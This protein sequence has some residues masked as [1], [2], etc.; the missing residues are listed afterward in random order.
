[1]IF[2]LGFDASRTG[3][4][5]DDDMT[6]ALSASLPTPLHP[7]TETPTATRMRARLPN[8]IFE[9]HLGGSSGRL[10]STSA[11]GGGRNCCEA[12]SP[13]IL[14]GP[15]CVISSLLQSSCYRDVRRPGLR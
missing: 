5:A 10:P 14:R 12:P 9:P 7:H 4:R 8:F 1:M 3:V 13:F 2:N 15:P 11:R 6:C